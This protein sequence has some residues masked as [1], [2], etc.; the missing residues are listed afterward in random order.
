M[1]EI[2]EFRRNQRRFPREELEQYNGQYVAWSADGA[3][4]LAAHH[5][6]AQ[7]DAMLVAAGHDPG[8]ILVNLVAVPEEVAWSR[9]SVPEACLFHGVIGRC[10]TLPGNSLFGVRITSQSSP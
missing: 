4:I 2:N 7:L 8:E 5:N 3:R 6:P 10:K 1:I 9:W